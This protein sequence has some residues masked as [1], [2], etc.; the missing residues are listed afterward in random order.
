[1]VSYNLSALTG[2]QEDTKSITSLICQIDLSKP[3]KKM[4]H[5]AA[6][7]VAAHFDHVKFRAII[8]RL[9]DI[10]VDVAS[11]V[12]SLIVFCTDR[13]LPFSISELGHH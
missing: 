6:P 11:D 8:Q 3:F 9:A 2:T 4:I 1:M 7:T 13:L 5:Q 10:P 12:T